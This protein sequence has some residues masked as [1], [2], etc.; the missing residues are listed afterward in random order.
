MRSPRKWYQL[1]DSILDAYTD[2]D[3]IA[4]ADACEDAIAS[5]NYAQRRASR[6]AKRAKCQNATG[7]TNALNQANIMAHAG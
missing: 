7:A 3:D 5:T 1:I 4:L 6:I 2:Y